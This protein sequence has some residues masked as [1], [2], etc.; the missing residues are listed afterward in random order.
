MLIS[1]LANWQILKSI[2][3]PMKKA[4]LF[5]VVLCFSLQAK[6]QDSIVSHNNLD[7]YFRGGFL[8]EWYNGAPSSHFQLDEARLH[9]YGNY[10]ES[11]SY[12]IRFRLN[13]PFTATSLDNGTLALDFAFLSYR[14]GASKR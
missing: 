9:F 10:N 8:S 11:L 4:V 7:F 14:F 1:R 13:K 3:Y 12:H 2:L 6:A 5:C